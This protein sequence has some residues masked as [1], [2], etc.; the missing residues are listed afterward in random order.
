M[1]SKDE[2][3]AQKEHELAAALASAQSA[4]ESERTSLAEVQK[5]REEMLQ[6]Q[7]KHKDEMAEASNAAAE[8]ATN[9]QLKNS[10]DALAKMEA[11]D[12]SALSKAK[13]EESKSETGRSS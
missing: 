3:L 4:K 8:M 13:A 2:E 11:A 10:Q 12:D 7:T 5:A 9:L 1:S 6:M